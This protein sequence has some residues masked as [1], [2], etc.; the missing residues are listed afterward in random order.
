MESCPC[1]WPL[2]RLLLVG[3]RVDWV[4]DSGSVLRGLVC[5]GIHYSAAK[6][7]FRREGFLGFIVLRLGF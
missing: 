1:R 6:S 2:H 5:G 3:F 4:S 7:R